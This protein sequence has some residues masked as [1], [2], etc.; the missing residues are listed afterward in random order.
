MLVVINVSPERFAQ[1]GYYDGMGNQI[2]P[3]FYLPISNVVTRL[4]DDWDSAD[5][6]EIIVSG[7]PIYIEQI[8]KQLKEKFPAIIK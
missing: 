6:T 7:E 4:E 2:F 5:I 1:M 3:P 8:K